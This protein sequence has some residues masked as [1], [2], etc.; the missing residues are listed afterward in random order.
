[1]VTCQPALTR[2]NK[3]KPTIMFQNTA[4]SYT[5]TWTDHILFITLDNYSLHGLCIMHFMYKTIVNKQICLHVLFVYFM[6]TFDIYSEI[7][8][9][10]FQFISHGQL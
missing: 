1:M 6:G 4:T 8:F 7:T 3:L 2:L 10:C 9:E 5:E